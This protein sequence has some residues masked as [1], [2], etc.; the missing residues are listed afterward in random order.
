MSAHRSARNMTPA[1]APVDG[2]LTVAP[3]TDPPAIP[4]R[5]IPLTHWPD[6]H[7]WPTVAGLRHLVFHA[8]TNGFDRVVRRVGRRVL[9][10]EA[11]FMAWVEE[12]NS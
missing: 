2:P 9:I 11:A 8:G 3:R 1:K 10:D 4:P 7:P 12:Q 6:H 5:Y